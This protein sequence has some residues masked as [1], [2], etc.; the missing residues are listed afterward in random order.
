MSSATA[1]ADRDSRSAAGVSRTKEAE[2]RGSSATRAR[3]ARSLRMACRSSVVMRTWARPAAA[4]LAPVGGSG[5]ISSKAATYGPAHREACAEPL[6]LPT[7][8][9]MA[10][11]AG[12]SA[13]TGRACERPARRVPRCRATLSCGRTV[14]ATCCWQIVTR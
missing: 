1:L 3:A 14:H 6:P 9:A 5:G 2:P 11:E 13:G 10:V 8:T 4:R 12:T 7:G